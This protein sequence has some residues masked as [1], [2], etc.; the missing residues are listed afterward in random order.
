MSFQI[1]VDRWLSDLSN[2]GN[3]EGFG[4]GRIGNINW[5]LGLEGGQGEGQLGRAVLYKFFNLKNGI[6]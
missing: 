6:V 4:R 5:E 1:P 2:D 3:G